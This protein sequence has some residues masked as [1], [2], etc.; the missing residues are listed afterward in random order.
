LLQK[1]RERHNVAITIMEKLFQTL[2]KEDEK[3]KF[4]E[5]DFIN[6][7]DDY[8][9]SIV[10]SLVDNDINVDT[11]ET[12]KTCLQKAF[13]EE[14]KQKVNDML[15]GTDNDFIYLR[16]LYKEPIIN[17]LAENDINIDT[18]E[19]DL[20]EEQRVE[21]FYS[22]KNEM[23]DYDKSHRPNCCDPFGMDR[24]DALGFLATTLKLNKYL[25]C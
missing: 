7:K 25:Y 24:S 14:K 2:S 11:V 9:G 5:T 22:I 15:T 17:S 13:E 21:L 10:N 18:V 12:K 23:V 6:I 4:I 1:K 3:K 16:E 20:D 8:K 19:T